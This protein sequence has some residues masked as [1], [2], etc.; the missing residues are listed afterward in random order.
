MP[1][2][3]PYQELFANWPDSLPRRG[4]VINQLND[5]VSFKGFMIKG[6][7]LLLER[8]TPDAMGGRFVLLEFETIAAMKLTD[9]LK[10]ENFAPVGFEGRLA[11]A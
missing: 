2:A 10:T 3:N 11:L 1:T 6:S 9:P 8:Q 5:T 4:I 7:L